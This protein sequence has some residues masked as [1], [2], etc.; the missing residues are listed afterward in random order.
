MGHAPVLCSAFL[1]DTSAFFDIRPPAPY[2]CTNIMGARN[3]LIMDPATIDGMT[4]L[5]STERR[6]SCISSTWLGRRRCGSADRRPHLRGRRSDLP[7]PSFSFLL[8][9]LFSSLAP[10]FYSCSP[11]F[12]SSA[13]ASSIHCHR[14][15][16]LSEHTTMSSGSTANR[17]VFAMALTCASVYALVIQLISKHGPEASPEHTH[18]LAKRDFRESGSE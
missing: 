12:S 6:K 17:L 9:C 13:S 10:L 8:S 14:R 2:M 15:C 4:G 18:R 3:K 16:N 11:A 5:R 1:G 7:F